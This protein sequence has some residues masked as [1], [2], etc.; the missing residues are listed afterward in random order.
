MHEIG[1][2]I[3]FAVQGWFFATFFATTLSVLGLNKEVAI[4]LGAFVF[5]GFMFHR[6][7]FK[8]HKEYVIGGSSKIS[9]GYGE[10]NADSCINLSS[11]EIREI[12]KEVISKKRQLYKEKI[13]PVHGHLHQEATH[14]I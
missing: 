14:H 9:G 3:K 12:K 5:A 8:E 11:E 1:M 2:K 13:K 4:F 6:Y 7:F 10:R